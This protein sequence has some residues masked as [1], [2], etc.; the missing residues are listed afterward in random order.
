MYE[1]DPKFLDKNGSIDFDATEKACRSERGEAAGAVFA[2]IARGAR[3]ALGAG[4]VMLRRALRSI[5]SAMSLRD[6]TA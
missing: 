2:G 4:R 3:A 6:R 1:I 5:A